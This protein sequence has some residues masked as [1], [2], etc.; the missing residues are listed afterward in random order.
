MYQTENKRLKVRR[1]ERESERGTGKVTERKQG[2]NSA[3]SVGGWLAVS[4]YASVS[5]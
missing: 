2:K 3:Y 5:A 4:A 1:R